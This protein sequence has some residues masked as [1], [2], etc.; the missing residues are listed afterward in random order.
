MN[1]IKKLLNINN[2]INMYLYKK[3]KLN[4]KRIFI[5]NYLEQGL[6]NGSSIKTLL[7]SISIS[8]YKSDKYMYDIIL[9]V[10]DSMEKNGYSDTESLYRAGLI[11]HSELNA[12]SG[13]SESEPHKAY[14]FIINKNKNESNLKWGV[15][16]L[17]APVIIVLIG[18]IIFQPEL[19]SLTEELLSPVNNIS[20]KK[21]EIPAYF[22]SRDVFVY[23]LLGVLSLIGLFSFIIN[24]LKKYKIKY[25]FKV[26]KIYE[27]E[28]V[29][30]SISIFQSLIKSGH[31]PIKA[32]NI[33]SSDDNDTVTKTIFKDIKF[34]QDHGLMNI[35]EVL[36]KYNIDEATIAYIRSGEDNNDLEKSLSIVLDYNQLKYEA[37]T[38]ILVKVLPLIGE[39]IMTLVLLKPLI[40]IINVTTIGAMNFEV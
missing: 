7:D 22:E 40:D 37:L 27:R 10:L 15:G 9:D 26:L 12:I 5:F 34:N 30:N 21:I 32:I 19:K 1:F 13:I 4:K 20:T 23:A 3:L 28:F 2:S 33:L 8:L 39:I 35:N 6:K 36:S 24:L 38:K 17:V 16:M 25:L 11:S 29:I 14:E 18:F 31:S